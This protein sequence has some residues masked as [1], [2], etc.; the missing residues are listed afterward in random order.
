MQASNLTDLSAMI[1]AATGWRS[2]AASHNCDLGQ[3]ILT[4]SDGSKVVLSWDAEAASWIMAT[5]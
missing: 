3:I 2:T 4:F 5:L 1:T